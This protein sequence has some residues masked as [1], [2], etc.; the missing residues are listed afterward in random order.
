MATGE[1]APDDLA[2]AVAIMERVFGGQDDAYV[3]RTAALE[4]TCQ[5][6]HETRPCEG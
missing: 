5:A 4:K 6:C 1:Q 2:A 3:I